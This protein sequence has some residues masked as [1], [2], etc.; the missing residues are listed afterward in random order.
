MKIPNKLPKAFYLDHD[1]VKL[2]KLLLGKYLWT[3]TNGE[4]TA[5][6][7]TETEA[8]AGEIDKASHAFGGRHTERT[9]I[10]FMEGGRAYVYLCYGIHHL[11]NV[12]VSDKG[13]PHAILVRAIEP[14]VGIDI[15][16]NKRNKEKVNKTLTNGPGSLTQ[17]MGITTKDTGISLIGNR[18][19]ITDENIEI[20]EEEIIA[21]PRVG[22]DYAEEHVHLPWR[23]RI[24]GNV[25][26]GK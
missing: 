13:I 23:F 1:V 25:F 2:S 22:I 19:W 15:M 17:A 7:I 20:P 18:I 4:V 10:M 5:G 9:K 14:K 16:L 24:R 6:M 21:S 8:Y 3:D 26:T 11:F 12:V